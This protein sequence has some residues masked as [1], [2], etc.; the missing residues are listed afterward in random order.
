MTE[1]HRIERSSR[2]LTE[3]AVIEMLRKKHTN[4][5]CLRT[6]RR[7][8]ECCNDPSLSAVKCVLT[9]PFGKVVLLLTGSIQSAKNMC[10][11]YLTTFKEYEWTWKE[12]I[13]KILRLELP[14]CWNYH[15]LICRCSNVGEVES[16][17]HEGWMYRFLVWL[18]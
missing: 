2:L 4:L 11:N 8:Y 14:G 16:I 1:L 3:C 13:E 12:N 15:E 10:N 6:R 7:P 18:C 9:G 5:M 17:M